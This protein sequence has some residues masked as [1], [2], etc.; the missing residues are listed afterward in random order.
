MP[1]LSRHSKAILRRSL[2]PSFG[3]LVHLLDFDQGGSAKR[4]DSHNFC[5]TALFTCFCVPG[6]V[7]IVQ[8]LASDCPKTIDRE[9]LDQAG[10]ARRCL[11][12]FYPGSHVPSAGIFTGKYSQFITQPDLDLRWV[13]RDQPPKV[14]II[15]AP[16]DRDRAGSTCCGCLLHPGCAT[17]AAGNRIGDRVILH[18]DE[19]GLLPTEQGD[20]PGGNHTAPGGNLCQHGHRVDPDVDHRAGAPCIRLA[21]RVGL[22]HHHPE[23]FRRHRPGIHFMEPVPASID[24]CGVVHPE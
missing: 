3:P 4:P 5:R 12:H 1:A 15:T 8:T 20:E 22:D 9:K 13:C 10:P 17:G 18:A 16:M 24:G 14:I 6:A 11:L 7:C 23:G 2:S 21:F 19:R